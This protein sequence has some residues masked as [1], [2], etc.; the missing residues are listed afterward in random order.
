MARRGQPHYSD[1]AIAMALMLRPMF[2]L[3]LRQTEGPIRSIPH[4]LGLD[5]ALPDHGTMSRRGEVARA[6]ADAT[7]QA[8]CAPAGRQHRATAV[9]AGRMAAG[10]A[11]Q[12][13][14]RLWRKLHLARMLPRARAPPPGWPDTMMT[15]GRSK[16]VP[17]ACPTDKSAMRY[18]GSQHGW[19]GWRQVAG[20]GGCRGAV[21]A[22]S[23]GG[24]A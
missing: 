8:A 15:A 7:W 20:D 18:L 1:L 13:P 22:G 14:R 11:R 4:R 3:A 24:V 19:T 9:P 5:L 10:A 12:Q 23:S 6:A 17:G 2:R 21:G 16:Q